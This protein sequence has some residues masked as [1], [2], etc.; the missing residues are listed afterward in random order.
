MVHPEVVVD[1]LLRTLVEVATGPDIGIRVRFQH[2]SHAD[3]GFFQVNLVAPVIE[4]DVDIP[5]GAFAALKGFGYL[6]FATVAFVAQT[7]YRRGAVIRTIHA[8]IFLIAGLEMRAVAGVAAK[9]Q[10]EWNGHVR[11]LRSRLWVGFQIHF[12]RRGG[13]HFSL[14]VRQCFIDSLGH[15]GVD[16]VLSKFLCHYRRKRAKRGDNRHS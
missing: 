9:L 10:A 3:V 8:D 12:L 6:E 4:H 2:V 15:N 1:A 5:D 13:V 16:L 14:A 7:A 11:R